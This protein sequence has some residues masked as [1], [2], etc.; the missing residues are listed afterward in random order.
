MLLFMLIYLLLVLIR[1]QDYPALAGGNW[2]YQQGVLVAAAIFWLFS[3]RKS[4][5]A[6]QYPLL[7]AFFVV[8]M[9]SQVAN[10]WVGGALY[11]AAVFIPVGL[12]FTLLVHAADTRAR[13]VNIMAMFALCACV[14]ALHGIEQVQTGV[15]WTGIGLSQETRIQYVGIFNDPNDLG[16]LFVMCLPMAFYLSG[17]GGLMGL[18]RLFWVA[19][20][21][22]LVYGIYLTNSRGTLLALLVILGIYV[23]RKRGLVVAGILGVGAL[24]GLLMLPS[25]LQ[26]VDV[27][28]ESAFGRVDSWYEGLQ[29]FISNPVFGVGPGN[30]SDYN[31]LTAHNSFMLVLAETGYLGFTVWLAFVCYGFWMMVT[32][33]R[34]S[35]DDF[36]EQEGEDA[37]DELL[38]Q[39]H[40][41]RRIAFTLL[42][43][44]CGFFAAA[45]FL[46]RSYVVTLYL[47][48]AMVVAHYTNMRQRY[49]FLP[50]FKLGN[51]VLRWPLFSVA[52]IVGLFITV[53]IL[54]AMA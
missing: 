24:G 23:W 27:S 16:M 2:P 9:L 15:G 25:R 50:H 28:E 5:D 22:V 1:P 13:L 20:A 18:R 21:A 10:G 14:L 47:L 30:Y 35:D 46:S 44:L 29:M 37:D 11:V 38:E 31:T 33:V 36:F 3:K 51:D 4:F 49:H 45:F 8:L 19:V 34:R 12:A 53:K 43:S 48:A 41:D 26:D 7:L 39:W 17:Q 6:P 32:V 42:L 52:A 54:L 40:D